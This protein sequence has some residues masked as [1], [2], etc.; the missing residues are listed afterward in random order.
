[1]R[2]LRGRKDVMT[3]ESPELSEQAVA[4]TNNSDAHNMADKNASD[5]NAADAISADTDMTVDLIDFTG[6]G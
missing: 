4:S 5:C 1:M 6:C 2:I 3:S